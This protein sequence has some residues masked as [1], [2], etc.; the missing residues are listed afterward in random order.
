M[1]EWMAARGWGQAEGRKE[2]SL[3][4]RKGL[5]QENIYPNLQ[6]PEAVSMDYEQKKS[7]IKQ[8]CIQMFHWQPESYFPIELT[9]IASQNSKPCL[10]MAESS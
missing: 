3:E 10:V 2:R 9:F 4:C 6:F 5:S 7:F 8:P 1:Y